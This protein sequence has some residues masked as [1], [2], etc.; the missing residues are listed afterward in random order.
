MKK[1][2]LLLLFLCLSIVASAQNACAFIEKVNQYQ[3]SVKLN[4]G[5]E[6][7]TIDSTTFDIDTYMS[8]FE[9]LILPNG[10]KCHCTYIDNLLDGAPILFIESD[11]FNL[12]DYID[13]LL[14]GKRFQNEQKRKAFIAESR[15]E[16][17]T[18]A[19]RRAQNN[20]IPTDSPEGY[21]QYLLFSEMGE[22]FALHWHSNYFEKYVLCSTENIQSFIE[23]YSDND[24][25]YCS[26]E[27][28]EIIKG[29]DPIPII[30]INPKEC[31]ITW[32][33]VETHNGVYKRTYS[34]SRRKPY[35]Y[36]KIYEIPIASINIGFIY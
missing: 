22:Q 27:D 29:L 25:F 1:P 6:T 16:F 3:D 5:Q 8:F 2:S 20:V 19:T 9:S 10:R 24:M 31:S 15:Y 7:I 23:R 32:I 36:V 17:V 30:E 26:S 11:S 12:E 28:L 14:E 34:I 33:E 4:Y 35:N 21:L 18:S 13:R